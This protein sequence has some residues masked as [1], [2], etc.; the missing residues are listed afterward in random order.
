MKLTKIEKRQLVDL[1]QEQDIGPSTLAARVV[2]AY[3]SSMKAVA[4]H[5]TIGKMPSIEGP[6]TSEHRLCIIAH[7]LGNAHDNIKAQLAGRLR[8]LSYEIEQARKAVDADED[9]DPSLIANAAGI[10]G[11]IARW[12]FTIEYAPY[13]AP[14]ES[15]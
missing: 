14:E 7:K 2:R 13:V 15:T 8:S 12:N 9:I 1:G 4:Q 6:M 10:D 5:S 11:L 3:L